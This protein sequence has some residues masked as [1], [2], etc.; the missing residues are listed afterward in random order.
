MKSNKAKFRAKFLFGLIAILYPLLVFCA[1]VVFNLP[2]RYMSIGIIVFAVIYSV[3]NSRHYKGKNAAAL[4]I[5]PAIL[6]VIGGVSL[7]VDSPVILKLYPALADLAYVTIF[8]TSFF[9]PPPFA[10]YFIEIFD[11]TMKDKIPKHQF[12]RYCF[13]ATLVWC[14]FFVVD[15][16]IA[17]CTVIWGS[18]IIWAIYNSGITYVAMGLIF[19]GEFIVIK[20]IEKQHRQT[21]KSPEETHVDS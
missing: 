9:F 15:G 14:C 19:L 21:Q 6:C 17:V 8:T 16:I 3:V 2:I 7:F 12:E 13:K 4:F 18:D 1:L 11:R 10:F 20:M 5:S